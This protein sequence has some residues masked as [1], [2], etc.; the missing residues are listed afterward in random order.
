MVDG[1]SGHHMFFPNHRTRDSKAEP[2]AL[3]AGRAR[4]DT[5]KVEKPDVSA[6]GSRFAQTDLKRSPNNG[7]VEA[8]SVMLNDVFL[9]PFVWR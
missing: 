9:D 1:H 5:L 4:L 3:A 2:T 7:S 8:L 6:F